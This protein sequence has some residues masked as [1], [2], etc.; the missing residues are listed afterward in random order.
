MTKI[1]QVLF[2]SLEKGFRPLFSIVTALK[3]NRRCSLYVRTVTFVQR[4]ACSTL[5]FSFLS[6]ESAMWYYNVE[7]NKTQKYRIELI[8]STVTR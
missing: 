1:T 3:K 4:S 6:S 8:R 2:C 5:R 7:L